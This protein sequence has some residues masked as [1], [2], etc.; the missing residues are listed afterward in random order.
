MEKAYSVYILSLVLF[1]LNG[2]VASY[3]S[4]PSD[5]IVFLR[6]LIGSITLLAIFL[7]LREKFTFRRFKRD[8]VYVALSGIAMGASWIFLYEAYTLIGVGI[9][10]LAYYCGPIL[11]MFLAPLLFRERLTWVGIVSFAVVLFGTF[12]VNGDVAAGD[13][14]L[15]L[16]YGAMSAILHAAM[17]I[18]TKKATKMG[19]FENSL[20][21]LIFSFFAVVVFMLCLKSSFTFAIQPS[22]WLPI[23]ILGVFNTG[24]C[25][26]FYFSSL[27]KL[28]IQTV[29]ILGYLEP[30]S[31][32]VFASLLLGEV[33]LPLQIFGA[34]LIL[35][36]AVA[37]EIYTQRKLHG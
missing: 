20:W 34:V 25:C 8:F 37:G 22:D 16:F 9:S 32:V 19:G 24:I 27:G 15:G 14:T 35:G 21:Q 23:L 13:N 4:L 36:G 6:T 10:S 26:Y 29:S 17:V 1:G 3:I 11:V 2:V 5:E 31:A 30:L 7:I 18:F 12:L 33:M 28:P